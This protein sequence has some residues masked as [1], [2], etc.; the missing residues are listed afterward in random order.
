MEEDRVRGAE[1]VA[2]RRRNVLTK[3]YLN[4][5]DRIGSV[6]LRDPHIFPAGF[7]FSP[8]LL[9]PVFFFVATTKSQPE[10]P[11]PD[12]ESLDCCLCLG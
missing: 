7:F 3:R 6:Q 11:F 2:P 5:F 10:A 1:S 4:P 12:L 9:R 8:L